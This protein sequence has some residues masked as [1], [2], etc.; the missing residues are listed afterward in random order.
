MNGRV[1]AAGDRFCSGG[2][3]ETGDRAGRAA[4][5]EPRFADDGKNTQ[6]QA[7]NIRP[8]GWP[9]RSRPDAAEQAQATRRRSTSSHLPGGGLNNKLPTGGQ[10]AA[11]MPRDFKLMAGK[12]GM[13]GGGLRGTG[14]SRPRRGWHG[15]VPEYGTAGEA[16]PVRL[17]CRRLDRGIWESE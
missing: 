1:Q 9:A 16:W 3:V 12:T 11:R 4:G 8:K 14:P 5:D 17:V 7:R 6:V 15:A 10:G 2:P 13:G